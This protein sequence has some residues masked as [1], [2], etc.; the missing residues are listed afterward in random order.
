[1]GTKKNLHVLVN[2]GKRNSFVKSFIP[3]SKGCKAP[4]KI[5][6]LGPKRL[7]VRPKILRS[8]KVK[9]A[10]DNKIPKKIN[11]IERQIKIINVKNL[12]S[13]NKIF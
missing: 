5:I 13:F 2:C 9:K 4:K 12:L 8:N 1:M 7:C 6:L 11:I 3:S 10:I